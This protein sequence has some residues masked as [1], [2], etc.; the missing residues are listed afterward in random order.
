MSGRSPT[1]AWLGLAPTHVRP[2]ICVR[3]SARSNLISG[4]AGRKATPTL[5]GPLAQ[6]V[7]PAAGAAHVHDSPRVHT[8]L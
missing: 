2:A 4:D 6:P 3:S 8:G 1:S 7:I 5:S